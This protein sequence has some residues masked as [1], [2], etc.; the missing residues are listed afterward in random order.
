MAVKLTLQSKLCD[1]LSSNAKHCLPGLKLP[2]PNPQQMAEKSAA[3]R[4]LSRQ[5]P[6]AALMAEWFGRKLHCGCWH[7]KQAWKYK[8]HDNEGSGCLAS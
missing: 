3:V 5:Y 1:N 2:P 4:E 7:A 6:D 8:C